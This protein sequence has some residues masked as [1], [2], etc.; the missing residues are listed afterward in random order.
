[1]TTLKVKERTVFTNSARRKVREEGQVPAVIYGKTTEPKSISLDSI[2]LI[3]T[4]RDEG[5]NAII[6]LDLDGKS[7]SVM[8]YEMQTDPLK[9][10]ITHADFY[11]VN[12][13]EDVEV[14]VP[15]TLTGDAQGVKDGGVLQQPLY[16]A[17]ITAKPG[18]IPQTIEVDI[19]ELGVN[20]T[21]TIGDVKISGK[22]SFNHEK[23]EVVASILPPQQ[24][25]EID[26]GEEQEPGEPENAEGR[27]NEEDAAEGE[28]QE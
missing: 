14:D 24:E 9:N 25:E 7:H 10:E 20:D 6:K 26:S 3:K 23:D 5:R 18:E 4:L 16:Q 21:L 13:K 15:I 2:E 27:E 8:L 11:V 28:K 22:Y 12:M 1:M 19:S 17:S